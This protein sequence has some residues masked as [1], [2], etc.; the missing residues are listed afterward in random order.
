MTTKEVAE[1]KIVLAI[2]SVIAVQGW[3]AVSGL[4]AADTVI[5][6]SLMLISTTPDSGSVRHGTC[7]ATGGL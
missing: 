6:Q 1:M 3:S 5:R 4:A 2:H 7:L